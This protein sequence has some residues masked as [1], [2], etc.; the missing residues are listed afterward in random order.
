MT[1]D[2]AVVGGGPAGYTAALY[3]ARAG[4]SVVVFEGGV[5]GGQMVTTDR[6]EN[7]P[8]IAQIDGVSLALAMQENAQKAGAETR[9]E[10]V[11]SMELGT[12]IKTLVTSAGSFTARAVILAMGAAPR[13]LGLE[14]EEK[15]TGRGVSY[16]ATCDGMFFK[17]KT[18]AVIGG[19]DSAAADALVLSNVCEKV[20]LVH[21]RDRL[22]AGKAYEKPLMEREN[23]EFVYN[24]A[25]ERLLGEDS[26]EGLEILQ[27]G[28]RR[29]LPV[30]G[31]F[32]AI[33]RVP[34]TDSVRGI[35]PLDEQGYLIAGEDTKTPIPGVFAAGDVRKKPLR[36]I[37]TAA[38]DG[39]VAAQAAERYL[40]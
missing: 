15:L 28:T 3:A 2:V 4:F 23:I 32:A 16:C 26:V 25:V 29:V 37:V 11:T 10:T 12:E 7:V 24:A 22:R 14:N 19:G 9:Y 27:N 33:G 31:V 6:I 38:A 18:V 20:Y 21:R 40:L 5:P 8:G 30:R 1:A 34:R 36:Q 39:A 17:G 35:L 13:K